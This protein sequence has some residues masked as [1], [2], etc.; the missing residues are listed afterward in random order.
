MC[1]T[2]WM[3][4][5]E[6]RKA[7]YTSPCSWFGQFIQLLH[8]KALLRNL[9]VQLQLII[10]FVKIGC[11]NNWL[12]KTTSNGHKCTNNSV[13]AQ[14]KL[15]VQLQWHQLHVKW[16]NL[17]AFCWTDRGICL[18]PDRSQRSTPACTLPP[19]SRSPPCTA[20]SQ[21]SGGLYRR[22]SSSHTLQTGWT[23]AEKQWEEEVYVHVCVG[24]LGL[25]VRGF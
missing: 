14:R 19:A 1:V 16:V 9:L 7:L 3:R 22:C 6:S 15:F 13:K 24:T 25:A 10:C 18:R 21:S 5:A 11:V 2:E 17:S 20:G 8:I 23:V 4:L 12:G